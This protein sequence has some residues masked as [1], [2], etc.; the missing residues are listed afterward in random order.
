MSN[1]A[2]VTLAS[3]DM[4]TSNPSAH[5]PKDTEKL[6]LASHNLLKQ[7]LCVQIIWSSESR[8]KYG[9]Y[10]YKLLVLCLLLTNLGKSFF[11]LLGSDLSVLETFLMNVFS[12]WSIRITA[13]WINLETFNTKWI[14]MLSPDFPG[15]LPTILVA[16][17][18][19]RVASNSVQMAFKSIVFPDPFGPTKSSDLTC[20]AFSLK[21]EEPLKKV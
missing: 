13:G 18:S 10:I 3:S 1:P 15:Y 16:V 8:I 19:K 4:S 12:A 7:D 21:Y 5:I 11:N 9:I 20:G 2:L 6:Q 14:N 17:R